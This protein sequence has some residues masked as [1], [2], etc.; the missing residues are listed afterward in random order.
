MYFFNFFFEKN[1]SIPV[2]HFVLYLWLYREKW[3]INMIMSIHKWETLILFLTTS[4]V[5]EILESRWKYL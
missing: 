3:S 4:I 1:N 2:S 5:F